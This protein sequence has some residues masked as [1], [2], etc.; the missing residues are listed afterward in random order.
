MKGTLK[1]TTSWEIQVPT[2]GRFKHVQFEIMGLYDLNYTLL[3]H[4]HNTEIA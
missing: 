4:L 3:A 2:Q 1:A